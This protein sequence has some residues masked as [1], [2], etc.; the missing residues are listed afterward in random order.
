MKIARV[1]ILASLCTLANA[2]CGFGA[3]TLVAKG[4]EVSPDPAQYAVYQRDIVLAGYLVL[5]AMIFDALDGR[6]AR[7]ARAT[8]DFGGQLDSLS[9]A[10]S[11]GLAPAFLMNRVV[12]ERLLDACPDAAEKIVW[13]AWICG[14]VYLGCA[15][16]RLARFNVENVHEEEAH[17]SFKGLPSPAAAGAMVSFVILAMACFP[18]VQSADAKTVLPCFCVTVLLWAAPLVAVVLGLLMVSRVR[19]SHLLNVLIRGRRPIGHLVLVVFL[20]ALGVL[21]AVVLHEAILLVGFGLYVLSGPV[22][23]LWRL[24]FRR[25]QGS[26]GPPSLFNQPPSG[27]AALV[28]LAALGLACTMTAGCG[29]SSARL[30]ADTAL[31]DG[32]MS[33][34]SHQYAYDGETVTFELECPVGAAQY[35]VFGIAGDEEVVEIPQSA[36]RYRWTHTFAAG[37]KGKDYEV[38]AR[39]FLIRGHRDYIFDSLEKKWLFYPSRS[40]KPDVP[41]ADEQTMT[42]TCYRTELR[43]KFD[44]H[45]TPRKMS[46]SLAKDDGKRTVIPQRAPADAQA[47]GFFVLGPDA[48]TGTCEVVYAPLAGEVNRAGTTRA[49]LLIEYDDGAAERQVQDF[50]TP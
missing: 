19:Y 14:G 2:L 12:V 18:T 16:I 34:K 35:I 8:S 42:I 44:M 13:V 31:P 45:G 24:L 28:L 17:R 46:L 6:L 26:G 15:L 36:G 43:M 3:I 29:E 50:K 48:K 49:E 1:S 7:F 20:I 39:P 27:P 30:W 5:V 33:L 37:L 10:I 38:Y 21:V 32:E 4:L 25:R 22:L 47:R 40:D 9:D 23:G 11:F 41:T